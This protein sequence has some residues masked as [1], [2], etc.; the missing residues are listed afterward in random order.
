MKIG[1]VRPAKWFE[2][3]RNCSKRGQNLVELSQMSL[4]TPKFG[5]R[6]NTPENATHP[7]TQLIDRSQNL[8]FRVCCVF[9]VCFGALLEGNKEHPKTQHTRKRRF[10][11]RSVFCIFG[12]VAFSGAF[13]S[14]LINSKERKLEIA[15]TKKGSMVGRLNKTKT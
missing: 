9:R 14:P 8:R 2:I 4:G 7:K 12:C 13:C 10:S 1:Q 6:Q 3:G 15:V 11:E 5:R